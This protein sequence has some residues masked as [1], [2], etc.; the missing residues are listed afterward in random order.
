MRSLISYWLAEMSSLKLLLLITLVTVTSLIAQETDNRIEK[1]Q[2]SYEQSLA[3]AGE[4]LAELNKRYA[5]ELE[6]LKE[7]YQGKG[8]LDAVL[9]VETETKNFTDGAERDFRAWPD[10]RRLR[11][12]YEVNQERLEK[13][14]R[15]KQ[16]NIHRQSVTRFAELTLE[17]TKNGDLA[18][19]VKSNEIKESIEKA[20]EAKRL[21]TGEKR[22]KATV[23]AENFPGDPLETKVALTKGQTFRVIPDPKGEWSGGGTK[24]GAFCDYRGYPDRANDWM[25]MFSQVGTQE[26]EPVDP[27]AIRTATGD[28]VLKLFADDG[29]AAGNEGRIKVEIVLN[30]R[31]EVGE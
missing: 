9:R 11:N 1:L 21:N 29:S 17:Y 26:R 8:D 12:I 23:S 3:L 20:I 16:M 31:P 19:A 4:P 24:R 30:P 27:E 15:E 22:F 7:Q 2:V 13:S 18:S 5:E 10:L 6:R 25:R 14:V 28:G